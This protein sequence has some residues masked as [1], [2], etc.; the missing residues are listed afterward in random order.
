MPG[1]VGITHTHSK[2]NALRTVKKM[3][4]LITHHDFYHSSNAFCD[5]YIG[6]AAVTISPGKKQNYHSHHNMITVWFDG[7]LYNRKQIEDSC[8]CPVSSDAELIGKLVDN[9]MLHTTV[10]E[11]DGIFAAA[12][13]DAAHFRILLITDRYGLKPLYV[14]RAR[15]ELAWASEYKAFTALP[16]FQVRVD[17]AAVSD[18]FRAGCLLDNRT[19]F[20]GVSMLEPASLLTFDTLNGTTGL[21]N[22]WN[23][24]MR[25]SL[26]LSATQD[27]IVEELGCRF[28]SAVAS[29]CF[30]GEKV[31]VTLS[32]GLD[33]RAIF[34]ALPS[35]Y[36]PVAISFGTKGCADLRI[37]A[38][39]VQKRKC[40][41]TTFIPSMPDWLRARIPAVWWLE[42]GINIMHLHSI[43]FLHRMRKMADVMQN[44]FLGDATIGGGY[45]NNPFRN[46]WNTIRNRGRRSIYQ[47]IR[48][49]EIFFTTRLPFFDNRFF[50]FAMALPKRY[51]RFSY[52]YNTMLLHWFPDY[53]IEI[54]WQKWGSPITES[55]IKMRMRVR[56]KQLSGGALSLLEKTGLFHRSANTVDYIDYTRWM[57][58]SATQVFI[59]ELLNSSS[60]IYPEFISRET[61]QK[62][63]RR[64]LRGHDD[65][66]RLLRYVT[67]EIWLQQLFHGTMRQRQWV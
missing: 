28:N 46:E 15:H 67:F 53:F 43:P 64:V 4:A 31:G 24:G 16:S 21:V 20:R 41:H 63:L 32:G 9:G 2:K 30:K 55:R 49:Q 39:V 5:S 17:T 42:C 34:A 6:A 48:L 36:T 19:W 23:P 18:F 7:E 29:R 33:S 22:Y 50:D 3:Q 61:A 60:A 65:T 26:P 57:H 52:I 10:Q 47:G 25:P 56:T 54:P 13:Y 14:Y 8:D 38:E 51:R 58:D 12:V 11:I 44:G 37:A 62:T 35:S 40:R 27:E 1:I 59:T 45:L 66:E